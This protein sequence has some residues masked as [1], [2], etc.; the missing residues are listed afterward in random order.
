MPIKIRD[1]ENLVMFQHNK[2]KNNN[3]NNIAMWILLIPY[4]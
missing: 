2:T 4:I 3:N 1:K